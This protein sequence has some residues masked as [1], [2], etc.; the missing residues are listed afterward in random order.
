[1]ELNSAQISQF[2]TEGYLLLRS[3]LT[4]ADLN[5]VIA[6]YEQHINRR[7]NELLAAGKISELYA[8]QPFNHRL[9]S[10]CRQCD[11]IYA[12]LDIMHFRGRASFEF[13]RNDNLLD[14]IEGLVGP[15]ITCG[16]VQHTRAKLP[17]G[18][19]PSA[20]DPH[21]APWHQDAGAFDK[22]ADPHF[23][24]TVW[25]PL[26]AARPENGCL[27]IIPRSHNE[28]LQ[29]HWIERGLVTMDVNDERSREEGLTLP[30]DKGDLL[31][32]HKAMPHRSTLNKT[33]EVRWSMDLRYQQ[34]GTPSGRPY[35]PDFA[36]RS[37][38]NPASL[39]T[40]YDQWC[41]LWIEAL[42]GGKSN[43]RKAPRWEV[44]P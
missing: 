10:I 2:E 32:M 34:T 43:K 39:L 35:Y 5:P 33:D 11:E 31:L 22:A 4:D 27:Q 13:L 28:G 3:V 41:Q 29:Q 9:V 26:S 24:L 1:M 44:V 20:G 16:P 7:A 21:I 8:D 30:M 15:E 40:D 19:T 12:N 38:S 36:V 18:L 25:L 42:E 14:I 6:E 17:E 37:R 23:V